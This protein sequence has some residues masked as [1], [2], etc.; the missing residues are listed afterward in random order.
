[1]FFLIFSIFHSF[2]QNGIFYTEKKCPKIG[3]ILLF[4]NRTKFPQKIFFL[5][6]DKISHKKYEENMSGKLCP[7]YT[8]WAHVGY[9][10]KPNIY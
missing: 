10:T 6:L 2:L 1:M 3:R 9:F 8:K 7:P 4:S 5:K